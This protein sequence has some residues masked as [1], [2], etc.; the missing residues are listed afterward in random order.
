MIILVETNFKLSK[1]AFGRT[2]VLVPK[3]GAKAGDRG[4]LT[5]SCRLPLSL[6]LGRGISGTKEAQIG[7]SLLRMRS[8]VVL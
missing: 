3:R 8:R 6:P 1:E 7:D 4:A 2:V 5:A